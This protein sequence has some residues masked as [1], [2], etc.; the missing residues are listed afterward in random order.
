MNHIFE[1][2]RKRLV[3][4]PKVAII[5]AVNRGHGDEV[6]YG[7]VVTKITGGAKLNGGPVRQPQHMPLG[8]IAPIPGPGVQGIESFDGARY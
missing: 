6:W 3:Q 4:A 2:A 8:P 5:K 1:M 7:D